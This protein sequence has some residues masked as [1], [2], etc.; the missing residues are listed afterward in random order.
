MRTL[1][2]IPTPLAFVQNIGITEL[3]VL[4]VVPIFTMLIPWGI[5]AWALID[6]A[7]QPDKA[8]KSV[9]R[10]RVR[11]VLGI[12]LSA[13]FCGP[14]SLVVSVLYLASVRSELNVQKPPLG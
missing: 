1:A 14:V 8:W 3:L 5:A 10:D 9:G 12:V 6:A 7:G 4:S 2:M 13:L 11:W